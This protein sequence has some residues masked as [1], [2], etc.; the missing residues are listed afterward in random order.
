MKICYIESLNKSSRLSI[1]IQILTNLTPDQLSENLTSVN[2]G[3]SGSQLMKNR[4]QAIQ[5]A[6][7][8]MGV[9][10]RQI[11]YMYKTDVPKGQAGSINI[12]FR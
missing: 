2:P 9:D 5:Q 8:N 7:I 10:P 12:I 3:L 11:V 6:L 1:T 4:G